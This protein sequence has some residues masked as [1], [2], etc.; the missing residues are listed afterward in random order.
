LQAIF[1][2]DGLSPMGV[3]RQAVYANRYNPVGA[4]FQTEVPNYE[5]MKIKDMYRAILSCAAENGL[6]P[7]VTYE[8]FREL[9]LP[10]L[11]ESDRK[12]LS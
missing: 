12:P 7:P 8:V 9:M 3:L 10:N 11:R 6:N 5:E 4:V 2:V 1:S